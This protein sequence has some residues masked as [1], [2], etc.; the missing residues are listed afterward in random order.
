M[1]LSIYCRDDIRL[2]EMAY[3][4]SVHRPTSHHYVVGGKGQNSHERTLARS[5]VFLCTQSRGRGHED[6][7]SALSTFNFHKT[8]N[9]FFVL[10]LLFV[11]LSPATQGGL[12]EECEVED[13]AKMKACIEWEAGMKELASEKVK[14][15]AE[16][17]DEH[18][19]KVEKIDEVIT[20]LIDMAKAAPAREFH[21]EDSSDMKKKID[22]A[23]QAALAASKE[24]GATSKEA[25]LAWEAY[26]DIAASGL[27]NAMGHD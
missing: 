19:F 12:D 18:E 22:E 16:T 20:E 3:K 13:E 15:L 14:K 2:L 7:F 21:H 6:S 10:F 17:H 5:I 27:F 25:R 24:F 23:E 4:K 26:E 9:D 8:L 11:Q 1:N